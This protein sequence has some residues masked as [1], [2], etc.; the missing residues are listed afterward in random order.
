MKLC[1]IFNEMRQLNTYFMFKISMFNFTLLSLYHPVNGMFNH[2]SHWFPI[3]FSIWNTFLAA[4]YCVKS[5]INL[6]SLKQ[7]WYVKILWKILNSTIL[8]TNKN[9][10]P[11]LLVEK[12][13]AI[14]NTT[15]CCMQFVPLLLKA[16]GM[17]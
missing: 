1:R 11:D 15:G 4:L 2:R 8:S 7:N 12:Q 14:E 3:R 13:R 9:Y 16:F 5:Y 17:S 10:T 6:L